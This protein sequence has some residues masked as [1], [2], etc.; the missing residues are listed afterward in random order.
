MLD[1]KLSQLFV[2]LEAANDEK[3]KML[4]LAEAKN[5][6]FNTISKEML[7]ESFINDQQNFEILLSL[8]KEF[9]EQAREP[10]DIIEK[11]FDNFTTLIELI[12]QFNDQILFLITQEKDEQVKNLCLQIMVKLASHLVT[13]D[14]EKYDDPCAKYQDLEKKLKHMLPIFVRQIPLNEVRYSQLLGKLLSHLTTRLNNIESK[15]IEKHH[16]IT[17]VF[18]STV[19]D[20][21]HELIEE[22][23]KIA[24]LNS[25]NHVRVLEIFL[26]IAVLSKDH[27]TNICEE[28]INFNDHLK[29]LLYGQDFLVKLNVIELL[30][31]LAMTF[32]GYDYL[33]HKGHLRKLLNEL[34]CPEDQKDTFSSFTETSII[35]LFSYVAKVM[36]E[37]V[38]TNFPE[39]YDILFEYVFNED[40]LRHEEQINLALQTFLYLFESNIVKSFFNQK[41]NQPFSNLMQTLVTLLKRTINEEVKANCISC[42]AHIISPDP[43]LLY[44]DHSDQKYLNSPWI[45]CMSN[46]TEEF[47][48]IMVSQCSHEFLFNICFSLAKAPF[49]LTRLSAQHYFK[50]LAQSK[51]GITRLFTEMPSLKKNEF[52][53][54][55]LLN[56]SFEI[57][58]EGIESKYKLI[59]LICL[60]LKTN[61]ELL[62]LIG[63][64]NLEALEEYIRQGV[65]YSPVISK[66]AYENV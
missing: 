62:P 66:V 40:I 12:D 18:S 15:L 1:T 49:M 57:E 16:N 23:K 14:F 9:G 65:Y 11:I 5:Y 28:T 39:Y 56:R 24:K 51:W 53:T 32:H 34:L 64:Y 3:S 8:R 27:L 59:Q 31:E 25:T 20:D 50:A 19:F 52:L 10:L 30:S 61:Y 44:I 43:S 42:I 22:F 54:G 13:D 21:N 2:N 46:E 37:K 48:K 55:Y 33:D 36:P 45:S 17:A 41:F 4:I 38:A 63:E 35:K 58:K 29:E 26:H 60:N 47:Y 6:V 7:K